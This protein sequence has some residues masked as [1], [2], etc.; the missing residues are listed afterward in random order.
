MSCLTRGGLARSVVAGFLAA[1]VLTGV[2]SAADPSPRSALIDARDAVKAMRESGTFTTRTDAEILGDLEEKGFFAGDKGDEI[3]AELVRFIRQLRFTKPV[4][5]RPFTHGGITT[6]T[7]ETEPNDSIATANATSCGASICTSIQVAGDQDYFTY[8]LASAALVTHETICDGDTTLTLYDAAATQVGFD[9]DGGAGLCSLLSINLAAGTY[10]M[11]VGEFGNNGTVNYT[12]NITCTTPPPPESEPNDTL[13]QANALTCGSALSAAIPVVG[14]VDWFRVDVPSSSTVTVRTFNCAGDT[15]MFL[16]DSVGT[17]IEF[18]DDDGENLCSLITRELFPGTYYLEVHEFLDDGTVTYFVDAACVPLAVDE[19]EPNNTMG[20]ANPIACGDTKRAAH[21]PANDVDF[22]SFTLGSGA[23][24]FASLQCNGDSVL[25]LFD[26]GGTQIAS[27]NDSGPDLCSQLTQTLA[28]GSYFLGVNENGQDALFE[29][30]LSL[31]CAETVNCGDS[32]STSI[33]APGEVDQFGLTLAS[34]QLVTM[35]VP[36]DGDAVLTVLDTNG[37]QVG[38][39]D[40]AVGLCPRLRL[41]LGAGTYFLVINEFL[42]DGTVNYTLSITCEPPAPSETEPNED[43]SQATPMVCGDLFAGEINPAGTDVDFFSFTVAARSVVT[44][45]TDCGGDTQLTLFDSTVTQIGFDD[46]GGSGLCSRLETTVDAGTYSVLVSEFGNDATVSYLLSLA[47]QT[48]PTVD[49]TEPNDDALTANPISCGLGLRGTIDPPGDT[50]WWAFNLATTQRLF[51]SVDTST[52]D[53]DSALALYTFDAIG[54]LQKLRVADNT[55]DDDPAIQITLGP[56]PY[57]AEVTGIANE[58]P[59]SAYTL[60]VLCSAP[61]LTNIGCIDNGHTINGSVGA[62]GATAVATYKGRVGDRVRVIAKSIN[63]DPSILILRPDGTFVDF[64]DDDADLN[65]AQVCTTLPVAGDYSVMVG[66]FANGTGGFTLSLDLDSAVTGAETEPNNTR[67]QANVVTHGAHLTGTRSTSSDDDFYRFNGA[68]N[69]VVTID[70]R[71]CAGADNT[72]NPATNLTVE[73]YNNSNTLL[74]SSL[75]DGE[76][77]DPLLTMALPGSTGSYF[78]RVTGATAGDYE[79]F[80]LFDQ[81]PY[82]FRPLQP[83]TV[84]SGTPLSATVTARNPS[85]VRKTITFTVDRIPAGGAPT[86]IRTRTAQAPAGLNKTATVTLGAAPAVA[87]PT[88]FRYLAMVTVG[89]TSVPVD[90]E[91]LVTP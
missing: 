14:D 85:A 12:L 87:T 44:I 51:L 7:P 29:Y 62:A 68:V 74:A 52:S 67:A 8:T 42:D 25:R 15:T 78:I 56:G 4:E 63:I 81:L 75:D 2:A 59:F 86:R 43:P 66:D 20:T 10:T 90:F 22:W 47:C 16:R 76:D 91:V 60:N 30:E 79:L 53:L 37:N 35:D 71:T 5:P 82:T 49:E 61:S 46:D 9:D 36:C 70:V 21:S 69:D 1:T 48:V 32:R 31:T 77:F 6:T 83:C 3:R 11:R 55:F 38:F 17:E 34:A 23:T 28:A 33:S 50:D 64:D 58:G 18:D 26:A 45:E 57:F 72:P 54:N 84:S 65:G 80:F 88:R 13:G 40:D 89:Q 39:S 41:N 24:I 27:D 19:V 73:V